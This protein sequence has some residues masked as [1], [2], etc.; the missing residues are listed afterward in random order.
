MNTAAMGAFLGNTMGPYITMETYSYVTL[1]GIGIFVVLFS[2]IPESPYHYIVHGN[3]PKAEESLKWFKREDDVKNDIQEL[4]D[5]VGCTRVSFSR[6]FN[7][8]VKPMHLK[9]T[10]HMFFL[11]I[12]L[13]FAGHNTMSFYAEIIITKTEVSFTP[14][15][16]VIGF[17][18]CTIIASITATLVVDK[19]GRRLLLICSGIGTALAVLLL[20]LHFH[21]LSLGYD[22]KKITWL[23]IFSILLYNVSVAYGLVPVPCALVGELFPPILKTLESMLFSSGSALLSFG[24]SKAFQPFVDLVGEKYVFWSFAVSAAS[25]A[26]YTYFFIPETKGKSLVEIQESLKS[27]NKQTTVVERKDC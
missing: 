25:S 5:F 10:I 23:P 9:N 14:S 13:Y 18:I 2:F 15:T 11:N 8:F 16:V 3:I 21:M 22:G 1:T 24:T 4:Q 20:G 27:K 26:T 6:R 19:F 17:G 12:F 7:E